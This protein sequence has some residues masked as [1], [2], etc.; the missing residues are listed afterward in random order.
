MTLARAGL[1]ANHNNRPIPPHSSC[2]ETRTGRKSVKGSYASFPFGKAA[3]AQQSRDEAVPR[4]VVAILTVHNRR[5]LTLV[6]LRSFFSQQVPGVQLEAVVVDDGSTDGT[7][8]AVSGEF[9]GAAVI[10]GPGDLFWARGMATAEAAAVRSRPDFLLWL[11]DDVQLYRDALRRLLATADTYPRRPVLLSGAVCDP[12]TG[13]TTYGGANRID[14]HPMR[15]ALVDP[16]DVPAAVDTVHGNVLLVPRQTYLLLGGID[17]QFAHSYADF[18]YG[19]RLRQAGGENVLIAGHV[20][21]C[22]RND[23]MRASLDRSVPLSARWRFFRSPKGR[24]LRSQLRYLHRHG[25]LFWLVFVIP[26]YVRML[27]GRPAPDRKER[28]QENS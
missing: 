12:Q 19:L 27:V 5:A 9:P 24:P 10:R 13:E 23:L 1:A 3:V 11:N 28:G 16:S 20:G 17:G 18:D 21:T 6:C 14:W 26:P 15:Y 7:R 22:T 2:Y 4:R 8:E 25:G